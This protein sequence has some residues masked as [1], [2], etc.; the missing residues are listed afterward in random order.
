M[1]LMRTVFAA[2]GLV[3]GQRS[4]TVHE[5]QPSTRDRVHSIWLNGPT[6]SGTVTRYEVYAGLA[7]LIR[8]EQ[9]HDTYATG[10]W[11]IPAA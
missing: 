9:W 1:R 3:A 2:L 4:A 5:V 6:F 11:V 10:L 8:R 7:K